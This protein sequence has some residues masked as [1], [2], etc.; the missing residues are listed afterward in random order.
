[1]F[2]ELSRSLRDTNAVAAVNWRHAVARHAQHVSSIWRTTR[3]SP[4]NITTPSEIS[5]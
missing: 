4:L 2:M 3:S 5:K 1:M